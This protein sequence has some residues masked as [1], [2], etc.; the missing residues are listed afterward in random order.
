MSDEKS[1]PTERAQLIQMVQ[2]IQ[3]S[4]A[5]VMDFDGMMSRLEQ[6]IGDS[7]IGNL[8]FDPPGGKALT[9]EEIVE[10]SLRRSKG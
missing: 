1:S 4:S 2:Q 7:Q 10:Q 9:A 5:C 3:N 6:K 8:I